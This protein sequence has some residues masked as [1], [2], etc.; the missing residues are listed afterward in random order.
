MLAASIF[1]YGTYTIAAAKEYL[2]G[3]GVRVRPIVAGGPAGAPSVVV[4]SSEG[5]SA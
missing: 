5:S 1:H 2:A 4:R 3:R